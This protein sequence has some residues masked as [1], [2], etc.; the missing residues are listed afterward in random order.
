MQYTAQ[1]TSKNEKHLICGTISYTIKTIN[2]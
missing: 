2:C 1:K